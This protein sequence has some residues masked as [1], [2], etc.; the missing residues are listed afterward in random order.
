MAAAAARSNSASL[1]HRPPQSHLPPSGSKPQ[2]PPASY[3]TSAASIH[4]PVGHR[5]PMG[6]QKDPGPPPTLLRTNGAPMASHHNMHAASAQMKQ[7]PGNQDPKYPVGFKPYE[8]YPSR[9]S[10]TSPS[11]GA[12]LSHGGRQH[13]QHPPPGNE[14][15]AHS[16]RFAGSAPPPP[17]ATQRPP[18]GGSPVP[19]QIY[20]K[21]VSLVVGPT[22]G[23]AAGVSVA[24]TPP[25]A[26]GGSAPRPIVRAPEQPIRPTEEIPAP[27]ALTRQEFDQPLDL[28]LPAKRRAEDVDFATTLSPKKMLKIEPNAQLFK[29]SEPSVLQPSEPSIITTVV[30]SAL[31][32]VASSSN[33]KVDTQS[34]TSTVKDEMDDSNECGYVH[35]LKKAWIKAYSSDPTANPATPPSSASLQQTSSSA[36]AT[37]SPALSTKSTGSATSSSRGTGRGST[38]RVGG[39]K[40]V[41]GHVTVIPVKKEVDRL[42][43][44]SESEE[45]D[46][47]S[48]NYRSPG[49]TR[50]AKTGRGRGRHLRQ[51]VLNTGKGRAVMSAT[52][53][54]GE[55]PLE[56]DSDRDSDISTATSRKSQREVNSS[57]ALS[58]KRGR[59][60]GRGKVSSVASSP[61][62]VL[63][64]KMKEDAASMSS[65]SA[66]SEVSKR[67]GGKKKKP[68]VAQLKKT[69]QSFLQDASCFEVAPKLAKCRECRWTQSQ[70]NKKMPNIF[71]RFYA[72]RRV[73]YAKNG[74]LCVA[75]FCDPKR[76][77]SDEDLH[78]W[79]KSDTAS[80]RD[81]LDDE[82]SL[83]ILENLRFDFDLMLRQERLAVETH[84]GEGNI[85]LSVA[86]AQEL[87]I[88]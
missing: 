10:S 66:S 3:A 47:D 8:I 74:Q 45:D 86:V 52:A 75:G 46:D 39:S 83:F 60:P 69:G 63:N 70:R 20:G 33:D 23:P 65:S 28:G 42:T 19:N 71:C 17:V 11:P 41:N 34:E 40:P 50:G 44:S 59:K 38:S 68:S 37:P 54:S 79:L 29:V 6:Q 85:F 31:T 57:N 15:H 4:Y 48:Q 62:R 24:Q 7:H 88:N 12:H 64:K 21:P 77:V 61:S 13:Q 53:S 84:E 5:G 2:P 55:S 49:S 30:N 16:P 18:L 9:S 81:N 35:K 36:R 87:S 27:I 73:R 32:S 26:H 1:V 72:F 51:R 22:P 76:D 82:Q 14:R 58:R 67:F 25:P 80:G 56:G 43:S 78:L